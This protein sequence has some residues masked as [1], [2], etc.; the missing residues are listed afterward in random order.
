MGNYI[1]IIEIKQ[2]DNKHYQRYL[3]KKMKI[4]AKYGENLTNPRAKN[5]NKEEWQK[6]L[7]E[8]GDL[9]FQPNGWFQRY[10]WETLTEVE[11]QNRERKAR[12]SHR[13]NYTGN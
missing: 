5:Y 8:I 6:Y 3:K 2:K 13:S 9:V 7:R 1:P 4:R 11:K 10:M 12:Q